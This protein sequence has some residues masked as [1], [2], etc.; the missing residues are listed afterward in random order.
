MAHSETWRATLTRLDWTDAY[1]A[2]PAFD[3]FLD[4]ERVRIG[5]IVSRLRGA[6][7]EAA[8]A[9]EWVFPSAVIA[10][11]VVVLILLWLARAAAPAAAASRQSPAGRIVAGLV[12]FVALLDAAGFVAAGAVLFVCTAS[13]FGSRRLIRDAIVALVL[14]G[15]VYVMFTRGLGTPLP[16]GLLF[17]TF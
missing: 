8:R 11:A 14:C 17:S 16:P 12:A 1:L 13:A 5:R 6:N 7:G 2:G 4:E 9:G 10:G 15:V 3:T